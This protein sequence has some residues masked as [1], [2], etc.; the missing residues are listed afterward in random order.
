MTD[1]PA[2]TVTEVERLTRLAREAVD[3]GAAAAYREERASLLADHGYTAR[4]R[5]GDTGDVLVCY[6]TDWV[7]DGV[8]RPDR[9]DDT[10]RGVEVRLSG[11]GDPDEWDEV[12]ERNRAVAERVAAEHGDPHGTTAHALADFMGNHY[13]KPIAEATEDELAEF[14][15]EYFPR[16]AW[17]TERQQ[18][19]LEESVQLTVEEAGSRFPG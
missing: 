18:A 8:V 10:D 6:P 17:P 12:E 9:I 3:E 19:L 2:E 7:E 1:L 13:G 11:P 14:R 16:N 15:E 5:E 4:I